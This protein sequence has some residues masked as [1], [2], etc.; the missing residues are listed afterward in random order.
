MPINRL[1]KICFFSRLRSKFQLV[2]ISHYLAMRKNC[3]YIDEARIVVK[4]AP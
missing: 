1:G 4:G 2:G 3:F